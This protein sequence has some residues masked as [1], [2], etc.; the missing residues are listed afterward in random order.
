MRFFSLLIF[1]FSALNASAQSMNY[2]EMA[3]QWVK[4]SDY[5]FVDKHAFGMWFLQEY[6]NGTY[7]HVRNDE[8]ELNDAI[9]DAAKKGFAWLENVSEDY[10]Y[11]INTTAEF[12]N[13]DFSTQSFPISFD[14]GSMFFYENAS[15]KGLPNLSRSVSLHFNPI[16][17]MN[18]INLSMP[19]EEARTFLSKRKNSYGDINRKIQLKIRAQVLSAEPLKRISGSNYMPLRSNIVALEVYDPSTSKLLGKIL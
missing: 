6:M 5:K 9:D 7:N 12:G 19:K 8:F 3:K 1:V 4:L 16:Q 17:G 11:D 10:V 13:Y 15:M 18:S 14:V 2:D